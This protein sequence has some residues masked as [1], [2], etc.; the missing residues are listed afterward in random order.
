MT[1][2]DRRVEI[3]IGPCL[4]WIL[5]TGK[6]ID[7]YQLTSHRAAFAVS[8]KHGHTSCVVCVPICATWTHVGH[9]RIYLIRLLVGIGLSRQRVTRWYGHRRHVKRNDLDQGIHCCESVSPRLGHLV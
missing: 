5:T 8:L 2:F 3:T 1:P 7:R 9:A 4:R 6:I